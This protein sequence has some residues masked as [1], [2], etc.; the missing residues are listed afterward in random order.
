MT[1]LKKHWAWIVIF[2]IALS[3]TI[4]ISYLCI[5]RHQAFASGYDLGNM[6]DTVWQ[7]SQGH[8]FALTG[9]T[10]L[11]SRFTIHTDVILVF[12]A[13][14]YRLFPSPNLLLIVQALAI[15][16]SVVPIFLISRKVIKSDILGIIIAIVF[17]LSPNTL[18][19]NIYDF[20]PVLLAIPLLFFAFYFLQ[21]KRWYW[22]WFVIILSLL[23]K[24]NVGLYVAMLGFLAFWKFKAKKTGLAMFVIGLG[25][26]IIAVKFVMPHFA[27]GKQHWA[28]GWYDF[29]SGIVPTIWRSLTNIGSLEYYRDLLAP[30]GFLPLLALPWLI[31]GAP[32]LFLNVTSDHAEMKSLVFHYQSLIIVVLTIGLIFALSYLKKYPRYFWTAVFLLIVATVHQNYFYSPLPT[33]PGHW[34]LMYNVGPAEIDFEKVLEKIPQS[35]TVASSS[36]V[37]PHVINHALSYNLPGGV[38]VADYIAIVSQNRI[39][40]DYEQKPYE[41]PLLA[42]LKSDSHYQAIYQAE[43]FYLYKKIN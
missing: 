29:S 24:E 42:K 5:I 32:D 2:L 39:V 19:A 8:F 26:T 33:T 9:D 41:T 6:A 37:R 10:G 14:L 34:W 40:G 12:L 17:L 23:T 21:T 3:Y 36:E 15:G 16:I 4:F 1:F 31:P 22:L 7:T 28:F 35:A 25:F 43:P 13:P 30:Y 11:I 20:H 27:G 38:D 18:W